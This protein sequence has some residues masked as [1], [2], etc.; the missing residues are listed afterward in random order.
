VELLEAG[1]RGAFNATGPAGGARFGWAEL[2]DACRRGARAA[3]RDAA[4]PVPVAESLLTQHGVAPWTELPLWLPASDPET[5][6]LA[7]IAIGR[8]IEN[9]LR[10]RPLDDTVRA[11]LAEGRPAAGD[12]RLAGR[13]TP[14]REAALIGIARAQAGDGRAPCGTP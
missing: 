7:S 4:E 6:G 1:A 12:A 13:L 9:G 2:I 3:G 8:A 14:E 11:V 5:A 10:T